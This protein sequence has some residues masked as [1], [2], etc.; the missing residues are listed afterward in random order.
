MK[1]IF[2]RYFQKDWFVLLLVYIAAVIFRSAIVYIFS[3]NRGPHF[4][5][6]M[7]ASNIILGKGYWF[8]WSGDIPKQPTALLPPIYT[9][10]LVVFMKLFENPLRIIY[11]S[12]SFLNALGIIPAFYF[13]KHLIKNRTAGIIAACL[14]AFFPEIAI[15]PS[16][17]ISEPLFI[18]CVVLVFYLYL[19]WKAQFGQNRK[20][21]NFFWLG[22]ILGTATLIKTTGSLIILALFLGLAIEKKHRF[23]YIKAAVIMGFGFFI[24]ISPW[25]IRN[26]IVFNKPLMIA[27]NFGYNL[28]RGNNP[29]ASGTEYQPNGEVSESALSEEYREYLRQNRPQ[30]EIAMDKFYFN[31]AIKCIKHDPVRYIKLILKRIFYFIAIDLTHPLTKNIYYIGGY[32]FALFFGIWGYILLY[33]RKLLDPAFWIMPII[34]FC[35][36]VP[37][38]YVPRFRLIPVLILLLFSAIP[39]NDIWEKLK[40][41]HQGN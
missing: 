38:V 14:F 27:S 1:D 22:L 29:F 17:L 7:I 40:L 32:V 5:N 31:E 34:F 26:Y 8:G 33:K 4:E 2:K 19:K 6:Y 13:G 23:K 15:E 3:W 11:I 18:P 35:F 10:F 21:L 41:R 9:Y 12:Q 16:K 25:L 24:A 30:Q 37:V 28:W 36:Y 39:L 20:Y